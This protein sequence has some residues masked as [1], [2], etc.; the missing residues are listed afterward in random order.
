MNPY[1]SQMM[2][3]ILKA[4][5]PQTITFKTIHATKETAS[6]RGSENIEEHY[7][8]TDMPHV[9]KLPYFVAM[10]IYL[11][12][13]VVISVES[14]RDLFAV[15]PLPAV[16]FLIASCLLYREMKA[17]QRSTKV[18]CIC[19]MILLL[20]QQALLTCTLAKRP[21]S[22]FFKILLIYSSFGIKVAEPIPEECAFVIKGIKDLSIIVVSLSIQLK[23]SGETEV[24]I[25]TLQLV[26]PCLV[27]FSVITYRV[28]RLRAEKTISRAAKFGMKDVLTE[29]LDLLTAMRALETIPNYIGRNGDTEGAPKADHLKIEMSSEGEPKQE[30]PSASYSE[31]LPILGTAKC[32]R[33]GLSEVLS[34]TYPTNETRIVLLNPVTQ[35]EIL[36]Q[37]VAEFSRKYLNTRTPLVEVWQA[38]LHWLDGKMFYQCDSNSVLIHFQQFKHEDSEA[39]PILLDIKILRLRGGSIEKPTIRVYWSVAKNTSKKTIKIKSALKREASPEAGHKL[40]E[41]TTTDEKMSV[42]VHEM[43]SPLMCI[44]S[45]LEI[46]DYTVKNEPCYDYIRPLLKSAI[47]ACSLLEALVGDVLDSARISKGIFSV[48]K[49]T[50]NLKDLMLGCLEIMKIAAEARMNKL[51]MDYE[52]DEEIVSDPQRIKQVMLNFL[53]NSIKFTKA[54]EIKVSV[55]VAKD[56]IRVQVSDNGKGIQREILEKLF[57]KF[58]SNRQS[59]ENTKGIGLGL[60]ICK[61]LLSILGPPSSITVK[62]KV[63][64][65]THFSFSLYNSVQAKEENSLPL[66]INQVKLMPKRSSK[67]IKMDN[68]NFVSFS[69]QLSIFRY[70]QDFISPSRAIFMKYASS[71]IISSAAKNIQLINHSSSKAIYTTSKSIPSPPENIRIVLMED[72]QFILKAMETLISIHFLETP[73]QNCIINGFTNVNDSYKFLTENK[74]DIAFLDNFVEDGTGREL[75]RKL[76]EFCNA[77]NKALC[78]L[79]LC[80]G[81]EIEKEDSVI[82]AET[83]TK[84]ISRKELSRVIDNYTKQKRLDAKPQ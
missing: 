19:L 40:Q 13:A 49:Q 20:A 23:F 53:S 78:S 45:N 14:K 43:R 50:L 39:T 29:F 25:S 17:S 77:H 41:E 81:A 73:G 80:S 26:Y 83:L 38:L 52:G 69:P 54:G 30:I 4:L 6:K 16:G 72:D 61:S 15:V 9:H 51:T 70:N 7:R 22:S 71:K 47:S 11:M 79:V 44:Q 64:Q 10:L 67:E 75:A 42:V 76:A 34:H 18:E 84:P 12:N 48:S 31:L 27:M 2:D 46:I 21:F 8:K 60:F 56:L 57:E 68:N 66:P 58:N 24:D 3:K 62:S 28:I 5:V 32:G 63:G 37:E 74:V 59:E 35:D 82:F 36:S 1:T 55:S 65:G 33:V